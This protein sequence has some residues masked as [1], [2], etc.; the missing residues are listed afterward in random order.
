M[1]WCARSEILV[2]FDWYLMRNSCFVP[3]NSK[4]TYRTININIVTFSSTSTS[5]STCLFRSWI[6]H[7]LHECDHTKVPECRNWNKHRCE[8][9]VRERKRERNISLY[10]TTNRVP[11][12][13]LIFL[14]Y[15]IQL[16]N[17]GKAAFDYQCRNNRNLPYIQQV[18][19]VCYYQ[20]HHIDEMNAW[21]QF[22]RTFFLVRFFC[23]LMLCENFTLYTVLMNNHFM[24]GDGVC[25]WY[26]YM[27]GYKL[28]LCYELA[29][30]SSN[31]RIW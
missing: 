1:N 6:V 23:I 15:L 12:F 26:T 14:S 4:C 20:H 11:L 2:R 24:Y 25:V 22:H 29:S 19:Y 13:K 9:W 30:I 17:S 18:V 5:T 16:D 28:L 3:E 7:V 31:Y 8:A 27:G 21:V 10:C